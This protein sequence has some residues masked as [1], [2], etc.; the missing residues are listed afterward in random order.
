VV[1]VLLD[2]G[3]FDKLETPESAAASRSSSGISD[4]KLGFR[5]VVDTFG[6][7]LMAW[8]KIGS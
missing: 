1:K 5:L 4:P 3:T 2:F 6:S 7:W 8:K